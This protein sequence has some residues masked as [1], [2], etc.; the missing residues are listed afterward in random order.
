[1][2]IVIILSSGRDFF[3][4]Y[5]IKSEHE[6]NEIKLKLTLPKRLLVGAYDWEKAKQKLPLFHNLQRCQKHFVQTEQEYLKL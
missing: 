6:E 3:R 5:G 2:V 1:M 4:L